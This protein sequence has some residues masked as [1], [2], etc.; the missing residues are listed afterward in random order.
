MRPPG[1]AAETPATVARRRTAPPYSR[2]LRHAAGGSGGRRRP[3]LRRGEGRGR[4]GPAGGDGSRH[5]VDIASATTAAAAQALRPARPAAT[6]GAPPARGAGASAGVGSLARGSPGSPAQLHYGGRLATPPGPGRAGAAVGPGGRG[7]RH[8]LE[9]VGPAS[10]ARHDQSRASRPGIAAR[11]IEGRQAAE[12]VGEQRH[13]PRDLAGFQGACK[14][15]D[16]RRRSPRTAPRRGA[17]RM[18]SA[19][20]VQVAPSR[21]AIPSSGCNATRAVRAGRSRGPPISQS[22]PTSHPL[23]S[24]RTPAAAGGSPVGPGSWTRQQAG[25]GPTASSPEKPLAGKKFFPRVAPRRT[26][27]ARKSE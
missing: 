8:P 19:L 4:G 25:S 5:W 2:R 16:S 3:F 11:E 9:V 13:E 15:G 1:A 20:F 17:R 12:R 21:R 27:S 22:Q 14:P 26:A 18:S 24:R 23:G 7:T 6:R 10:V